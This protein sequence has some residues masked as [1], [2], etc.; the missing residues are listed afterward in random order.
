MPLQLDL[1]WY[2]VPPCVGIHTITTYSELEDVSETA[3]LDA[4][5]DAEGVEVAR[6]GAPVASL[7]SLGT[8]STVED[9]DVARLLVAELATGSE[10]SV[11]AE[12]ALSDDAAALP[13]ESA[14]AAELDE[15]STAVDATL[16]AVLSPVSLSPLR[17]AAK[18]STTAHPMNCT[19]FVRQYGI[20]DNKWGDL[21]CQKE[22]RTNGTHQNLSSW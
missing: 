7:E 19:P 17:L 3:M 18:R 12:L 20:L 4:L 9:A 13:S 6:L 5:S 16:D 15:L 21:L 1:L 10:L 14:S 22:N 8:S 11:R 2:F